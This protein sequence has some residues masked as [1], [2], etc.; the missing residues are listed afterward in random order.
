MLVGNY[1][2]ALN[3]LRKSF[4]ISEARAKTLVNIWIKSQSAME[5]KFLSRGGKR[6]N[7]K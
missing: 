1:S 5:K 3:V 4:M 6:V 7:C 2:Y